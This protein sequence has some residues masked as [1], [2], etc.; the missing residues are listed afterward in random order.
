MADEITPIRKAVDPF[1]DG[2]GFWLPPDLGYGMNFKDYGSYGLRQY[3]GWI[4]EE[5]LPQLMGR[6]A[7]TIYREMLDNSSVVGAMVFA[8]QQSIRHIEWRVISPSDNIQKRGQSIQQEVEFA[9]SV[10]L[11]M[12]HTW[13][14]FI[15]EAL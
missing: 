3:S 14:D 5:F 12:S 10:R 13:E 1:T 11:D 7:V 2:S 15:N 8:I 9:D 6:Q 4:R